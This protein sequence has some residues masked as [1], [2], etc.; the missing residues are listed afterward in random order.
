L[1]EATFIKEFY[2]DDNEW[3][4]DLEDTFRSRSNKRAIL[5]VMAAIHR[6]KPPQWSLKLDLQERLQLSTEGEQ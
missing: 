2:N 1:R 4:S 5:S 6:A 3:S